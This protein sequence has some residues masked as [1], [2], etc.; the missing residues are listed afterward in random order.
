M[1]SISPI[2]TSNEQGRSMVEIIGIL[3]IVG[4]LSIGGIVG[5]NYGMDKYRSNQAINNISLRGVDIIAR[6]QNG[7]DITEDDLNSIWQNEETI[8]PTSF[9]Y[10]EE[11]DRF[12]IQITGVPSS[13]C[14]LIGNGIAE[15]IETRI[16][17]EAEK[18]ELQDHIEECNFSNDN[19]MFF[20]FEPRKC[21]P[22]CHMNEIC[23][24]GDC[25]GAQCTKK[26][27]CN[28]GYTGTACSVCSLGKCSAVIEAE[29][30]ECIFSDGTVG[31]CNQGTCI[32]KPDEG[33]TYDTNPC[34]EGFYCTA[35]NTS[36]KVAF[37]NNETGICIEPRFDKYPIT[38]NGV[39][40]IWYLS[41]NPL[42]WWDATAACETQ[43]LRMVPM[44]HFVNGWNN[45]T[46]SFTRNERAKDLDLGWIDVWTISQ[47]NANK[48]AFSLQISTDFN[49]V[50]ILP[51]NDTLY[52]YALCKEV[53]NETC[54][55]NTCRC[56]Y[57]INP[58]TQGFY[59][60]APNTNDTIAFPEGTTGTCVQPQFQ[61]HTIDINGVTET[62]YV[63]NNTLSWWDGMAAC[64]AQNLEPVTVT[65]LIVN[66]NWNATIGSFTRNDRAKALNTKM[67]ALKVWTPTQRE[68]R[69]GFFVNLGT[70][71]RNVDSWSK[72]GATYSHVLCKE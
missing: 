5:Y 10:E 52:G 20:F 1:Y 53:N 33:C 35:S 45:T 19:T 40:E 60:A 26:E 55:P 23:I 16:M 47:T 27:D 69:S 30:Q 38:I 44:S 68:N 56:T 67:G 51:K 37:Q 71:T 58:C 2:N 7:E 48:S 62:W 6:T 64:E 18:H 29:G 14:R 46:G 70:D 22:G 9:F 28:Q 39:R 57:D 54:A 12:G 61:K 17:V 31:Q 66:T 21:I 59:C 3:V 32:E 24:D 42:S 25:R 65:E 63:S 4:V 43:N 8:Y 50:K 49:N 11:Y 41:E 36:D 13:V 15:H 72:S 34:D